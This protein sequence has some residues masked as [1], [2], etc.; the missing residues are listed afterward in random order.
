[1]PHSASRRRR[2]A[3]DRFERRFLRAAAWAAVAAGAVFLML[4]SAIHPAAFFAL[5]TA[6]LVPAAVALLVLAALS[7]RLAAMIRNGL[8]AQRAAADLGRFMREDT[9]FRAARAAIRRPAPHA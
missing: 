2:H 8:A 3:A 1:M 9:G 6:G 5:M 7:G 4:W